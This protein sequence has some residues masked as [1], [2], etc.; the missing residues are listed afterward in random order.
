MGFKH[1]SNVSH[2]LKNNRISTVKQCTHAKRF[3][4]VHSSTFSAII[5]QNYCEILEGKAFVR[6]E[7]EEYDRI[8]FYYWCVNFGLY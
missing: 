3:I 7:S 5:W 8:I 4:D 1:D 6:L 2:M